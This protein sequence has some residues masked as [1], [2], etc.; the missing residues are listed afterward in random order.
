MAYP[1]CENPSCKSFGK[2]HPNCRCHSEMAEGGEASPFCSMTRPHEKGC[3]YFAGGGEVDPLLEAATPAAVPED[4]VNGFLMQKGILGLLNQKLLN[5]VSKYEASVKAGYKKLERS[6]KLLFSDEKLPKEDLSNS[7]ALDD[8]MEKGG[9]THDI[10]QELYQENEPGQ[11]SLHNDVISITHPTQNVLLQVAK[12]RIYNY[13]SLHMPQKD[14]PKLAFDSEPDQTSKKKDYEKIKQVAMHPLGVLE[15]VQAGTILPMH[16]NDLSAMY[17][18][19]MDLLQK[20]ITEQ[21]IH[22]QLQ[23]KKPPS[24]TR[25]GL[26]LFM[27]IP[28]SSEFTPKNIQ[29][30]QATFLTT[31]AMG[32]P[33]TL[34]QP[35][36]T[37]GSGKKSTESKTSL[38]KSDQSFLTSSQARDE[39]QQSQH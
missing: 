10:Q 18:E 36:P 15:H 25:Q 34:P 26:S 32:P 5:D 7:K 22:M 24:R 23:G 39:R 6:I 38:S 33:D 19:I 31:G 37:Q 12:G 16:I 21:I 13:L 35:S 30:A 17:P 29:A 2:P 14:L 1:P 11:A 8:W 20:K 3:Q 9:I 27:G 28:L 4:E